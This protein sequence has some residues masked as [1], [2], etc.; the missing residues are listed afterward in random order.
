MQASNTGHTKVHYFGK[1][2]IHNPLINKNYNNKILNHLVVAIDYKVFFEA[3]LVLP[4]LTKYFL[5]YMLTQSPII[6]L[7]WTTLEEDY[8]LKFGDV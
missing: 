2:S 8:I 1:F 4:R 6:D 3:F 5:W 7:P